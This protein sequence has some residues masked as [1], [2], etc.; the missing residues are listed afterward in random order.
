MDGMRDFSSCKT[1]Q[2]WIHLK[3]HFTGNVE[4]SKTFSETS[5]RIKKLTLEFYDVAAVCLVSEDAAPGPD[6]PSSH[7]ESWSSLSSDPKSEMH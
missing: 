2:E 4:Y 7:G 6:I 3:K 5:D 1:K